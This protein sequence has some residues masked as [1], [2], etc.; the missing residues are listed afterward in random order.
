MC[1]KYCRLAKYITGYITVTNYLYLY[2]DEEE[3]TQNYTTLTVH[4]L[5]HNLKITGTVA[6]FGAQDPDHGI[7]KCEVCVPAKNGVEEQ[8]H[9]SSTTLFIAGQPP[10]I[11]E[12]KPNGKERMI[13][14]IKTFEYQ[15]IIYLSCFVYLSHF[16]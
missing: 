14:F 4:P 16:T 13:F 11:L 9:N 1:A 5:G 6:S 7:Y 12:G 10:V 8:C 15:I 3:V 2:T